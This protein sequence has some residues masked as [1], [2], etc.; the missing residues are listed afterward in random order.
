MPATR[1]P[2]RARAARVEVYLDGEG[3][4]RWRYVAGNARI[5]GASEQGYARRSY[6]RQKAEQAHPGVEIVLVDE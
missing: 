5:A 4:Y 1:V 3:L 2:R 6:A